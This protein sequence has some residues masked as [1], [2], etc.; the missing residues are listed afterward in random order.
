MA[1]LYLKRA[2]LL[3]PI[4]SPRRRQ[5]P[6]I[7]WSFQFPT[8]HQTSTSG[9]TE[10]AGCSAILV[11]KTASCSDGHNEI[12]LSDEKNPELPYRL[13][14]RLPPASPW[15]S[16]FFRSSAH[17]LGQSLRAP[18]FLRSSANV[19]GQSLS[20]SMPKTPDSSDRGTKLFHKRPTLQSRLWKKWHLPSHLRPK[21]DVTEV[22]ILP[23]QPAM[24][25]D[26]PYNSRR[27]IR[28][29]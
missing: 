13:D 3:N 12:K 18:H 21:S 5:D 24:L 20:S 23:P 6:E 11:L 16:N 9:V 15:G 28:L 4:F 29:G 10:L 22:Y 7:A 17:V 27:V 19:L 25:S 2:G 8:L 14:I 26:A 1:L